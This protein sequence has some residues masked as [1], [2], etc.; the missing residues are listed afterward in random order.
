MPD[1]YVVVDG[2]KLLGAEVF[3]EHRVLE[4]LMDKFRLHRSLNSAGSLS[5][6][7]C[8]PSSDLMAK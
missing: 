7:C 4:I 3:K 2:I 5:L 8:D 1:T 6:S